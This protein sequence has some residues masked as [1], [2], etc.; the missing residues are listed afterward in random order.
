MGLITKE[1]FSYL[2][3]NGFKSRDN[4]I[5]N[6]FVKAY[7]DNFDFEQIYDVSLPG[8][9]GLQGFVNEEGVGL[10]DLADI[11]DMCCNSNWANHF[12]AYNGDGH[13]VALYDVLYTYIDRVFDCEKAKTQF[14]CKTHIYDIMDTTQ[15]H[16]PE[17]VKKIN[18][19]WIVG[20]QQD[21]MS[22]LFAIALRGHKEL[23]DK[24]IRVL[25]PQD[26][27]DLAD[28]ILMNVCDD[29]DLQ[30]IIDYFRA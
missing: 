18:R 14:L 2:I 28:R 8:R 17:L 11:Y 26:A 27:Y 23:V 13:Y 24:G 29:R 9:F 20:S 10:K 1:T 25:F 19:L 12:Y 22:I 4:D 7:N 21:W 3:A 6:A 30:M 16:N 5:I 15:A